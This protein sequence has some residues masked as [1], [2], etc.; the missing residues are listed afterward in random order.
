MNKD[1]QVADKL[2]NIIALTIIV[3]I[4]FGL[5]VWMRIH[6]STGFATRE[7]ILYPSFEILKLS[8]GIFVNAVKYKYG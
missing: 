8:I 1:K 3:L 6:Q 5:M 7:L 2:K 4:P